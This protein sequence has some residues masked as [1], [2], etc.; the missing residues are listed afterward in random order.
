MNFKHSNCIVVFNNEKDKILFC[1]RKKNPH[2]GLYHFVGGKLESEET[3]EAAAYRELQE[4]TGIS[5]KDIRLYR[6]MDLT[7]YHLRFVLEIYVGVLNH[8][9][10]LLEEVN[11]L[12]WMTLDEDF[13]DRN[14]FAGEQNIVHIINIALQYPIPNCK[15]KT[16]GRFIGVDGCRGGWIGAVIE[17]G[18]LEVKRYDSLLQLVET[19]PIFDGFLI[20]MAIGLQESVSDI[21]P[22]DAARKMLAFRS[23]TIFPVPARPAVYADGEAQQKQAKF[24]L[25]WLPA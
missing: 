3:S 8:E 2:K 19:Y 5:R 10:A 15:L 1:K 14:R 12:E 21:R 20:D 9:K 6:L 4:E 7:Y 11:P 25:L 13:T 16:D 18:A 24:V 23:S 17:D 22:D